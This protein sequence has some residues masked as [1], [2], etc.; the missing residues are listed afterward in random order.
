[1]RHL[2][3]LINL[4]VYVSPVSERF[5]WKGPL[6]ASSYVLSFEFLNTREESQRLSLWSFRNV[7]LLRVPPP[8]G[9]G[10]V[11]GDPHQGFCIYAQ[12]IDVDIS[13]G[14]DKIASCVFICAG[15]HLCVPVL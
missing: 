9:V 14:G 2:W 3:F 1:M 8:G 5:F 10:A 15:S 13:A 6:R 4:F 11:P 12:Y 7:L